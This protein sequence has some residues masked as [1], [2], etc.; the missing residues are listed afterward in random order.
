MMKRQMTAL[1][2]FVSCVLLAMVLLTGPA[3]ADEV[4]VPELDVLARVGPWPAVSRLIA[5]DGRLWFANSVKGGDHNAADIYS[6]DPADGRVRYERGLWSQDAGY[7]LV[8]NGLLYWPYEDALIMGGWGTFEV[9][10]G[11]TWTMGLVPTED[12]FHIHGMAALDDRLYAATSTFG[13]GLQVSDDGGRT[14]SI[15]Y[16]HEMP[17][18][19]RRRIYRLAP[20]GDRLIANLRGPEGWRLLVLEDGAVRP[21]DGWPVAKR[22]SELVALDGWLYGLI[23]DDTGGALWRTDGV[24]AEPVT[25]PREDWKIV[26]LAEDADRL[27]VLTRDAGRGTLWSSTDGVT[28]DIAATVT[29]G[30]PRDLLVVDGVPFVG[31][32]GADD[33]GII[34]GVP[35]TTIPPDGGERATLPDLTPAAYEPVDDWTTAAERLDAMLGDP[36]AYDDVGLA[37]D[38]YTYNI[39]FSDPPD[40]FLAARLDTPRPG[41]ER[42]LFRDVTVENVGD[43]G[44]FLLLR[45]MGLAGR[46]R[47]DPGLL[48]TEWTTAENDA[49]KYYAPVV[50]GVWAA[51]VLGQDDPATLAALIDRLNRD[52]DPLWLKGLVIAALNDLTGER[53][54][55]DIE[56]WTSWHEAQH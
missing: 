42:H 23:E 22:L 12:I 49:Q 9:T 44:H 40:G 10:N 35:G 41:G 13:T 29:G 1:I 15:A 6:L 5:Y 47:I 33:A 25:A 45:A 7:P 54:G 46:D 32:S 21:L 48:G 34:W 26:D 36:V 17:D 53:F 51:G 8:W 14:W 16:T 19:K 39:A 30:R 31:G 11:E 2:R 18:T 24:T 27:W 3:G 55:H 37:L 38:T 52:A 28:W 56:A 43:I 50:A 4:D 20:L